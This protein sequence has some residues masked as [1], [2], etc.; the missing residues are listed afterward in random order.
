VVAEGLRI[1][2]DRDEFETFLGTQLSVVSMRLD[3]VR[4]LLPV[5]YTRLAT[6]F[7]RIKNRYYLI[8]D[9]P[10][11]RLG[12][13]GQYTIFLYH[14]SRQLFENGSR[15]QADLVYSLLRMVSSVDIF[16]EVLLPPLWACD[17][18]LGSVIGRGTFTSDSSLFFAQNCTIGNNKRL[19]P[20]VR[21]NL[22][23]FSNSALIGQTTV[24]GNVVLSNGCCVIDAGELKDCVVFGCGRQLQK[25][26][27]TA[28]KFQE[29]TLFSP[30][31]ET[32]TAHR[33]L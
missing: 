33:P 1:V 12:H 6:Q 21:G 16:Y 15:C 11:F 9:D 4:E 20:V 23:M 5:V 28:T 2:P 14:L 30:S 17:H 22:H 19:Y 18:P 32:S 31:W 10:V 25:K 24:D 8:D 3:D 27:L 13:N 29:I 7:G 26:P